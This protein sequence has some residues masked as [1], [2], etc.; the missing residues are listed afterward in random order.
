MGRH[1]KVTNKHNHDKVEVSAIKDKTRVTLL[2]LVMSDFGA[3]GH[4]KPKGKSKK[5]K[6]YRPRE[7]SWWPLNNLTKYMA[8]DREKKALKYGL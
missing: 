2:S 1:E 6:G 8:L 3:T 4:K 5:E 7:E